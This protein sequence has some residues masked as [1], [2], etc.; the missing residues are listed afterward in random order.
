VTERPDPDRVQAVQAEIREHRKE[1]HALAARFATAE[2]Q[3]P[4]WIRVAATVQAHETGREADPPEE[5][6]PDAPD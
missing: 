4:E 5:D 1:A 3:V 6:G 2:A